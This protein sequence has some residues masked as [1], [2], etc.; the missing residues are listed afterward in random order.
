MDGLF[1]DFVKFMGIV[2][3]EPFSILYTD[4]IDFSLK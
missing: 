4:S 2:K 3:I 1:F